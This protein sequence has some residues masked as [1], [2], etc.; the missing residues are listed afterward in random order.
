MQTHLYSCMT[1]FEKVLCFCL[2][3]MEVCRV[4]WIEHLHA[5]WCEV[6]SPHSKLAS[7]FD[8]G[9]CVFALSNLT[10]Y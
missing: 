4:Q 8:N 3:Q 9:A 1:C 6:I 2:N 10:N 5:V 7:D